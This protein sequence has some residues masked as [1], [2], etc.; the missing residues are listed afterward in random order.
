MVSSACEH[1]A[2]VA[3]RRERRLRLGERRLGLLQVGGRGLEALL[4]REVVARELLIAVV[5]LAGEREIGLGA[6]HRGR[7]LVDQRLLE[8]DLAGHA[9]HGR[10][11]GG[12]VGLGRGDPGREVA[13]V[14]HRPGRRPAWTAWLS[15]T[16]TART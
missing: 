12:E 8:R 11:L 3:G 10:R 5:V 2:L 6:R 7:R 9:L 15:T 16:W 14:D 13:I 1:G 4:A